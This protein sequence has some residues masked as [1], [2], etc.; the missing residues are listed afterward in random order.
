MQYDILHLSQG[1]QR[2]KLKAEADG[3]LVRLKTKIL[4]MTFAL[5]TTTQYK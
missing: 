5:H 1:D 3:K 2:K 4:Q